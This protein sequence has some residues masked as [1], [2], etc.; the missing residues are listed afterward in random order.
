MYLNNSNIASLNNF[1][2]EGLSSVR[3][4]HL[5]DNRLS[6][7]EGQELATLTEIKE[8]YLQ[9]N[10]L[11]FIHPDT[12]SNL[13]LVCRNKIFVREPEPLSYKQT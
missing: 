12:F 13:R 3:V 10:L 2:L 9:H 1:S 7:L 6:R 8:L 11:E 5:E 4:L